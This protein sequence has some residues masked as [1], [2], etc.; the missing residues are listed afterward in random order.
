MRQW[1]KRRVWRIYEAEY[2]FFHSGRKPSP[3]I[4]LCRFTW[5][6]VALSIAV[7][8]VSLVMF[9]VLFIALFVAALAWFLG[10]SPQYRS[11][12]KDPQNSFLQNDG[13]YRGRTYKLNKRFAP[14]E[15]A[16]PF[17]LVAAVVFGIQQGLL[18]P[19]L[20]AAQEYGLIVAVG[21]GV[22]L[23]AI[24]LIVVL[25]LNVRRVAGKV[26]CPMPLDFSDVAREEAEGSVSV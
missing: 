25:A 9:I 5:L 17:V 2:G 14:W 16:L 4:S 20:L 23:A 13:F 19:F 6:L 15:I 11:W 7:V 1:F 26:S 10:F 18:A 24:A 8:L 3:Q 21:L 22:A 12:V